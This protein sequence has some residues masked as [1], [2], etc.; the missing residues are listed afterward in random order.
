MSES[1]GAPAKARAS[2]ATEFGE[3]DRAL[4]Q[5][6]ALEQLLAVH[7]QTSMEQAIRLE[8]AVGDRQ[9][10]LERERAW[11]DRLIEAG[12][13]RD[14]ALADVQAERQRLFEVFMQAPA[15]ITVLEGPEHVFMVVNPLYRDLIGGRDVQGKSVREALPE[16]KGQGFFELLDRVYASGEPFSAREMLVQLDR[17]GDGVLE[18]LF[19]DFVYQPL[20]DSTRQVFGI[21]AHAVD[22]SSKVEARRQI[23]QKAD[24]LTRLAREL[25]QSNRELDQFAYVASHDLKAPL[26]GIASLAAWIEEDIGDC[27]TGDSREHMQLLK[28]RVTR[29]EGLI[30]GI[31]AYSRAGRVRDKVETVDVGALVAETVELLAPGDSTTIAIAP[32]MPTIRSE[33][34]ALQQVFINLIGNAIKYNGR[35]DARIDVGV[36]PDGSDCYRFSVADNGPGIAPQYHEKIWEI[37]QM[38]SPRDRVEGTGIGLSVVRKL[39]DTRGGRA[40]L[41]SRPGRGTTFYFTWPKE[42]RTT[43]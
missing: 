32:G 4:A 39:V 13:A 37:F 18:D 36:A 43:T 19:V 9:E 16:L 41:E 27:I 11:T 12:A 33:R 6:A 10:L 17:D 38:L 23:E 21:M 2:G 1:T 20:V 34:T 42:P 24:E 30:D 3:L 26:R 7:E 22:V 25:E 31:L 40:W 8:R 29:M 28:G 35:D 15:A 14:R 5:V